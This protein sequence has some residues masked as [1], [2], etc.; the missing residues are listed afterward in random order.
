M[1]LAG[2]V[3][4]LCRQD[5][6]QMALQGE[7]MDPTQ[8]WLAQLGYLYPPGAEDG[9][10]SV[11]HWVCID[12]DTVVCPLSID[13]A[14]HALLQHCNNPHVWMHMHMSFIICSE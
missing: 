7:A 11:T 10:T 5:V 9:I 6:R 1:M 13:Q 14:K 3:I 8:G 2:K 4:L 12:P